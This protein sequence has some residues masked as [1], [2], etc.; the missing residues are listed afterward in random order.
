MVPRKTESLMWRPTHGSVVRYAG[1][2]VSGYDPLWNY[3]DMLS[4]VDYFLE[5]ISMLF[6]RM[7][8]LHMPSL[9]DQKSI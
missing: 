3:T 2:E 9:L 5:M 6:V 8:K 4:S 7:I 1:I